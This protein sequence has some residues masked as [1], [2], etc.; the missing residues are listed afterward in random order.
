MKRKI[1]IFVLIIL[2]GCAFI[3]CDSYLD[4]VPDNIPTMDHA[5]TDRVQAEKFLYTLYSS[6]PAIGRPDYKDGLFDDLAWRDWGLYGSTFQPYLMLREGNRTD[7]PYCNYWEGNGFYKAIR[8][9]NIFLEK[10][11]Q[12][13]D[14]APFEKNRWIAET[15]FLK[16]IFH[17]FLLEQYG[18][19]PIINVNLP[20]NASEEE[21]M[22]ERLPVDE[23]FEYIYRLIDEAV[24]FLPDKIL[25]I[26]SEMGRLTQPAALAMKAKI[27]VTAASPLFNGN[28]YPSF[29]NSMGQPFFSEYDHE[30]WAEAID[31][32]K[33]AIDACHAAGHGLY[34]YNKSNLSNE[35]N[36]IVQVGRII[37]D[38][39][40]KEHIWSF[41]HDY[42]SVQDYTMVALTPELSIRFRSSI[43]PTMK[44]LEL[45]YSNNGV[46]LEED[47]FYDYPN[48]Y[49]MVETTNDDLKFVQ[50]GKQT[51]KLHLNREYRFYGSIA[52]DAGWWYGFG[53]TNEN[54][55]WPV[56]TKNGEV[57]G[58]KTTV[59]Y[60][61]SGC[62]IK[63]LTNIE[64]AISGT[65]F[66]YN[67]FDYPVMRMADLYLLYA[68]ALNEYMET[69]G[70][71]VYEYV[72]LVRRRAGLGTVQDSWRNFSNNPDKYTTR[73]GMREIIRR[74]RGIEMAFEGQR[75]YDLR[76]WKT[77]M[78]ELTG[79]VK[80]WN[81]FGTTTE[82]FYQVLNND[83]V[84]FTDR[85]LFSPIPL[86]E[87][88]KNP[89]LR[90]NPGW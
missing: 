57:S 89:K 86:S 80:G 68:E 35:T 47:K 62:Y 38:K 53:R 67:K 90:Q 25:N 48:R 11:D 54:D 72:N 70:D 52:F 85:D 77:A 15:K 87:M 63:K 40:N 88:I 32:C 19:I 36:K 55:Q 64:N 73:Q 10:I 42:S 18:P 51:A 20:I 58:P 74:E 82:E 14:L 1:N 17:Y 69:P 30:K 83:Y 79:Y 26:A 3:S 41:T 21:M 65:S 7:S 44:A 12:T 60:S 27:A 43:N 2:S 66:I 81:S 22:V 78:N 13:R 29:N 75:L 8:N 46:P 28:S 59:V 39:W 76:R 61:F 84:Q 34:E 23:V 31:A 6:L 71:E 56:N 49:E 45:F 5:F 50:A 24:P 4:L 16:A 33:L 37:T 9:C